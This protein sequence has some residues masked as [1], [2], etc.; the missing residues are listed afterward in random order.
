MDDLALIEGLRA[1]RE[2][3]VTAFL[4]RYKSLLHHCIGH[5][6]ADAGAR[7]DRYQDLVLFVLERLDREAYDPSRGSF[8]TWL[9]RVAWCRCVDLKRR[10]A[11]GG[12]PRLR[13]VGD[14]IPDR[15]D[16]GPGPDEMAGISEVGSVVRDALGELT[17][18]ER[19][20]LELRFVQGRTLVEVAEALSISIEQ[21]KYRLRRATISLRRVLLHNFAREEAL[22]EI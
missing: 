9:Y 5:F 8:G 11:A 22:T 12:R 20:L 13:A 3:A 16:E 21:T 6:E 18:E 4:E 10:D 14:E 1:R 17:S 15:A 7:E 19:S 2:A